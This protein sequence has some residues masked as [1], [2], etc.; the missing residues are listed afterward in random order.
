LKQTDYN[1]ITEGLELEDGFIKVDEM[2]YIDPSDKKQIGVTIHS[3][4]NH[5]VR[6][7]FEKLNYKVIKL[8]RVYF[9]GLT[10]KGLPRGRWRFLTNQEISMLKMGWE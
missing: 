8:D 7:I 2:E 1:A 10:K 5:I 6:R 9:C 4:R 3:G